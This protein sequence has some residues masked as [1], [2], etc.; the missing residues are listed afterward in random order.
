MATSDV[1]G[2][3]LTHEGCGYP[4]SNEGICYKWDLTIIGKF[5]TVD[6]DVQN[7]CISQIFN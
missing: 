2:L 4:S 1:K 6:V 5:A 3:I 7:H